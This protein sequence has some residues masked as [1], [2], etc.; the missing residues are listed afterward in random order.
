MKKT[1]AVFSILILSSCQSNDLE[2]RLMNLGPYI[3]EHCRN[4]IMYDSLP[5][6]YV[7]ALEISRDSAEK[8]IIKLEG[9]KARKECPE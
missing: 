3:I 8:L 9:Y 6:R 2:S 5:G 4:S 7:R 1:V